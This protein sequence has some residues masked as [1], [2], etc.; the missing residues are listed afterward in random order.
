MTT[1]SVGPNEGISRPCGTSTRVLPGRPRIHRA[2]LSHV[3]NKWGKNH[4]DL[5]AHIDRYEEALPWH[6]DP[7]RG[8][9]I[10]HGGARV[11]C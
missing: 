4:G 10:R 5:A 6:W 8:K 9:G 11:A 3:S 1:I 7:W 2:A